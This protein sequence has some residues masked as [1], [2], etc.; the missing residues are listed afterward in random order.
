MIQLTDTQL[1]VSLRALREVIAPALKD[2]ASHVVEQTHL[3]I[4][5]LE[6]AKQRL[7]HTRRFYREELRYFITYGLEVAELIGAEH[8]SLADDISEK[9]QHGEEELQRPEADVEDYLLVNRQLR[10][11]ISAAVDQAASGPVEAALGR[12]VL[13]RLKGYLPYQRAWLLPFGLDPSPGDLPP[14][15]QVDALNT[16]S[17]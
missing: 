1:Q 7:P 16:P 15:D 8:P 5:T 13:E 3:V 17:A 4:A 12:L 14:V 9:C 11:L 2:S 10:E 6:F